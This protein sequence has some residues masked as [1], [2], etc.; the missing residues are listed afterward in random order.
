MQA[1]D[2]VSAIFGTG[3]PRA[4]VHLGLLTIFQLLRPTIVRSA[5]VRMH[6]LSGLF[7]IARRQCP[8]NLPVL[9]D[10]C[11]PSFRIVEMCSELLTQQT[12][13]LV[14]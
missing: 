9:S 3:L 2:S 7:G 1:S 5:Q 13:P 6:C 4:A 14:E 10:D 11:G 8:D 12:A